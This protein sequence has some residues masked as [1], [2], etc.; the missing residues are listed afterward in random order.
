MMKVRRNA[1]PKH[2]RKQMV[3]NRVLKL[4]GTTAAVAIGLAAA[5]TFWSGEA[6]AADSAQWPPPGVSLNGDP[7]SPDISGLWLG[8]VTGVPGV[9]FA[10]NRGS[11][12]GRPATY[13][14]PWPLPYTPKFQAI[15]DERVARASKGVQLGD[16]SAKCMPFGL[17]MMLAAKVYPDEIVQTPGEVTLFMNNTFPI[18]IWTDGRDHPKDFTPSYNGHSTGHWVGDTLFVDT[19]AI[20]SSTPIDS[21]RNPHG[22]DIHIKW[23]IQKVGKDNLHLHVTLFDPAAFTEPVTTTNIWQ[24]KTEPRWQIL[25]DSSCFENNESNTTTPG[26]GF[27]KF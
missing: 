24:R 14:A 27:I 21:F 7:G 2:V 9:P 13:W 8:T 25:D 18:T 22:P 5:C 17:P 12:D 20:M 23:S 15:Y 26:E 11:A 3:V 6:R 10:P 1:E 16:S 4:V 19:V